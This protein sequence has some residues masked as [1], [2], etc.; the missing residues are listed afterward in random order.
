M[1]QRHS[2]QTWG[3]QPNRRLEGPVDPQLNSLATLTKE[4]ISIGIDG[5]EST[6]S[7]Y[8]MRG[9]NREI[10]HA[11]RKGISFVHPYTKHTINERKP[12]MTDELPCD[13]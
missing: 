8:L 13:S 11:L 9:T 5:L 2:F 7:S 1:E 10:G 4:H 6:G 12:C 3:L